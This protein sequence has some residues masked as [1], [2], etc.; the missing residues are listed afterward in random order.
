MGFVFRKP[1]LECVGMGESRR[2]QWRRAGAHNLGVEQTKCRIVNLKLLRV[3]RLVA[4]D[5]DICLHSSFE[6]SGGTRANRRAVE[7]A[8][9]R[10]RV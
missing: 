4:G 9:G 5:D 1:V 6:R 3:A 2:C 8:R 10:S 7:H